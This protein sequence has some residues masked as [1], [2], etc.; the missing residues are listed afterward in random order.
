MTATYNS[1]LVIFSAL[2]AVL[3]SYT[4]LDL[5][6]RVAA[7]RGFKR[8]ILLVGGATTMGIGI[9]SMH[10]IAMLAFSI[11]IS[12]SYNLVI[13]MVSLLAAVLASGL[14]LLIVSRPVINLSALLLGG[15]AM[16]IGITL[17]HYIGMAAMQMQA[18]IQYDPALFSLSVA[19]AIMASVVAIVLSLKCSYQTGVALYRWRI[20]SSLVMSAAILALHYTGMAAAMFTPRYDKVIE[21][22]NGIDNFYL[23]CFVGMFT[24]AILGFTLILGFDDSDS[25][26]YQE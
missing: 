14:A 7:L 25:E 24:L 21:P 16:G 13:V 4:A 26:S 19:I 8:Q 11:P 5:A 3:A 17:M 18:T 22:D 20:I 2:I 10:F 9:W 23:A 15:T 12:I 6:N 1:Y